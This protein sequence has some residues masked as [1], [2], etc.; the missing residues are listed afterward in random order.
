MDNYTNEDIA[1]AADFYGED[2]KALQAI[3]QVAFEPVSPCT[4]KNPMWPPIE[5][6]H[7]CY[8]AWHMH[9]A[10]WWSDICNGIVNLYHW[11]W[12]IWNDRDWDNHFLWDIMLKKL[13]LMQPAICVHSMRGPH[14][15]ALDRCIVLLEEVIKRSSCDCHRLGWTCG[16]LNGVQDTI[17]CYKLQQDMLAE[18]GQLFARFSASWWD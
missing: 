12:L 14:A 3:K 1:A 5:W 8:R 17:D 7:A 15:D 9:I 18:F 16:K 2:Y 4:L 10:Y 6:Y 11:G 13:K